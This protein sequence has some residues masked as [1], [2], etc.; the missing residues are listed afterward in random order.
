MCK[1]EAEGEKQK[2]AR[3]QKAIRV[4]H[5]Q[6]AEPELW[7]TSIGELRLMMLQATFA[8]AVQW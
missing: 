2:H 8:H 1:V 3:V 7:L 4:P 6:K 5:F